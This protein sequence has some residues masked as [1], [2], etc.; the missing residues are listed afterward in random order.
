MRVVICLPG[1]VLRPSL[2]LCLHRVCINSG[3]LWLQYCR[4]AGDEARLV[5]LHWPLCASGAGG[6]ATSTDGHLPAL[7]QGEEGPV[8]RGQGSGVHIAL[9]DWVVGNPQYG[10]TVA[11]HFEMDNSISYLTCSGSMF[12]PVLCRMDTTLVSETPLKL[13]CHGNSYTGILSRS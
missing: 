11:E 5:H 2:S 8:V 3:L 9:K 6:V 10:H 12:F 4:E 13:T 1:S 7:C